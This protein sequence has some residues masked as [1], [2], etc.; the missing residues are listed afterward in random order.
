MADALKPTKKETR[1]KTRR[2]DLKKLTPHA[3]RS[4]F[5]FE[6]TRAHRSFYYCTNMQ[7]F[8][9]AQYSATY[10]SCSTIR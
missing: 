6:S 9:I 1:Q 4:C 2:F 7:Y 3:A 8:V 5:P 10:W